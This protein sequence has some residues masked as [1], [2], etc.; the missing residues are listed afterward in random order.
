MKRSEEEKMATA[1]GI[2]AVVNTRNASRFLAETLE[3]LRGFDE[4]LVCDMESEDDTVEIARSYGARV[5]TFPAEGCTCVEPARN[6]AI[7]Q[8]RYEWVI[9]VDA[10][11]VIPE[12]LTRYLRD[13]AG[14]PECD[15]LFIARKNHLAGRWDRGS[16]PDYQLRFFRRDKCDWPVVVH[17]RPIIDGKKGH[18]PSRRRDLAMIHQQPAIR[19]VLERHNRYSDDQSDDLIRKG[20]SVSLAALIFKPWWRFFK[21]YILRG[22]IFNGKAGYISAKIAA[23]YKLDVLAKAFEKK[24]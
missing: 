9:L 24:M 20:K 16:Y 2:S 10:D 23:A 6:Y 14:E 13:Y 3:S 7:S 12:A 8:A 19:E 22:G 1:G 15:A 4:I 17:S 5:V 11:E 18:I 21:S